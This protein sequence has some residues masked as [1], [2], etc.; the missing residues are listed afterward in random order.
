MAHLNGHD[1]HGYAGVIVEIRRLSVPICCGRARPKVVGVY[2]ED[3]L[4]KT[5]D[6]KKNQMLRSRSITLPL[7]TLCG[8]AN[9]RDECNSP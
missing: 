4:K 2:I 8:H 1:P 6:L 5:F 3:Y 9:Y 7:K